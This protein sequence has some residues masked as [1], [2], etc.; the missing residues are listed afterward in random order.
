MRILKKVSFFLLLLLATRICYAD[1]LV[2]DHPYSAGT[3][4]FELK[5]GVN[6]FELIFVDGYY[7]FY[8]HGFNELKTYVSRAKSLQD[9]ARAKDYEVLP[10]LY[11]TAIFDGG[12]WHAWVYDGARTV[13]YTASTW[14]GPYAKQDT[15]DIFAASDW[16]V[17]KN[18]V[19]G[20]Y[21]GSYKDGKVNRAM[22]AR[23]PTPYGPWEILGPV[24]RPDQRQSWFSGEEAD[25]AIFFYG[26]KVY[27]TFSGWDGNLFRVDDGTQVVGVV[28]LDP[29]T[30]KAAAPA[31]MLVMPTESWQQRGGGKKLF[32]PVFVQAP[33]A[34]PLLVYAVN[35]SASG[36][37][38]GWGYVTLETKNSDERCSAAC[39]ARASGA[40]K[41]AGK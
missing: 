26:K 2:F 36:V 34:A 10:G 11:P 33:G 24:F 17:R 16:Q 28:E 14:N 35:P 31:N 15:I 12:V 41:T 20:Q 23:A 9:L 22:I 32:N 5:N 40:I 38:A 37:S 6:E 1:D 27:M 4:L 7:Y 29:H 18:P 39:V 25:A 21:Y 13:H 8:H 3:E 19:D 30:F